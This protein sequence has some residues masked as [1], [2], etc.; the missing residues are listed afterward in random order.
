MGIFVGESDGNGDGDGVGRGDGAGDGN[1]VGDEDGDGVGDDDG[2]AVGNDEG[3]A[4]GTD[5]IVGVSVGA[6]LKVPPVAFPQNWK[7][8]SD[9]W[10]GISTTRK[11]DSLSIVNESPDE[12]SEWTNS[13]V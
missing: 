7:Y 12:S 13:S 8:V 3:R 10:S 6:W 1:A 9:A 2:D 11:S 5:E 4:V